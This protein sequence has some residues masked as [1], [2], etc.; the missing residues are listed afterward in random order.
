M[1]FD[2]VQHFPD[3]RTAHEALADSTAGTFVTRTSCYESHDW[4]RPF[5]YVAGVSGRGVGRYVR[6]D[7]ALR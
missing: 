5:C 2:R 6:T 3:K 1:T 4:Y 7:G